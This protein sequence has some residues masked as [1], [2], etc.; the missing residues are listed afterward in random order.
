MTTIN[1]RL[2]TY[3]YQ[4]AG[5]FHIELCTDY[6]SYFVRKQTIKRDNIF[7]SQTIPPCLEKMT[8]QSPSKLAHMYS[9]SVRFESRP[10]TNNPDWDL[11]FDL[12]NTYNDIGNCLLLIPPKYKEI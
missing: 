12:I 4:E 9:E 2:Y 5:K 6:N 8:A 7:D 11:T 10:D 1:I 3:T